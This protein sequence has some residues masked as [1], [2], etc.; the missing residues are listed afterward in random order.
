MTF[1]RPGASPTTRTSP[2]S[3]AYSLPVVR[4]LPASPRGTLVASAGW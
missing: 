1:T 2:A 4:E 3:H